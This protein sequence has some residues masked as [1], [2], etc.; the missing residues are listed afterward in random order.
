MTAQDA[1]ILLT[2]RMAGVLGGLANERP[3]TYRRTQRIKL[4]LA[5]LDSLLIEMGEYKVEY[6]SKLSRI[7]ELQKTYRLNVRYG[8]RLLDFIS[9]AYEL[10]FESLELD[11]GL[12]GELGDDIRLTNVVTVRILER[13]FGS[14]SETEPYA[15]FLSSEFPSVRSIWNAFRLFHNGELSYRQIP[16]ASL[17]CSEKSVRL[18]VAAELCNLVLPDQTYPAVRE[19]VEGLCSDQSITNLERSKKVFKMWDCLF[20]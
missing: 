7:R 4:R 3:V 18:L 8:E 6:K 9:E 16:I 5:W 17:Y 14:V 2:N 19:I 15:K 13:L 1:Y 10:K 11:S 12:S 20:H